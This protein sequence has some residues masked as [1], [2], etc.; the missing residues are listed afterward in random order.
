MQIGVDEADVFA[1][2]VLDA[3]LP[4]GRDPA[5]D[6]MMHREHSIVLTGQGIDHGA[7][8]VAAAVVDQHDLT[9]EIALRED[10]P[11]ALGEGLGIF[12]LVET[13]G[14][15][16][17]FVDTAAARLRS[18]LRRPAVDRFDGVRHDLLFIHA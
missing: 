16:A 4:R 10:L 5:I 17:D 13:G 14:D 9:M 18:G 7:G 11:Q 1:A 15:D 8:G 3:G 12:H 2:A 6:R